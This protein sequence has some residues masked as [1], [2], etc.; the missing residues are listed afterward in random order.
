MG[1]GGRGPVLIEA[2]C[3]RFHGQDFIQLCMYVVVVIVV[4]SVVAAA[5]VLVV[6]VC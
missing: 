1:E 6:F 5:I 3:G 2:N 4:V